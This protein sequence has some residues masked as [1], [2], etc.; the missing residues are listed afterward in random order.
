MKNK[1]GAS[2]TICKLGLK[3]NCQRN[4]QG[5]YGK[6]V[7]LGVNHTQKVITGA[8]TLLSCFF[9]SVNVWV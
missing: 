4:S 1:A 9:I 5:L 3:W 6:N 2:L 7:M 8:S